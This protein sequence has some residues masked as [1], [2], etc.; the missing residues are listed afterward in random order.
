MM[1]PITVAIITLFLLSQQT[2]P[3]NRPGGGLQATITQEAL[4][5]GII[6]YFD[7]RT[8][9]VLSAPSAVRVGADFQMAI[10]TF[11]GGCERGGD[12]SVI[13]T[14]T[15]ATVIVYDFTTATRPGVVCTTILKRMPHVVTFRFTKPGDALIRVW[16]RRIGSETA[17]MG[18]P[19]VLE[20]RVMV[21]TSDLGQAPDQPAPGVGWVVSETGIG[22][23]RIGMTVAEAGQALQDVL[24]GVNQA[25]GCYFVRPSRGLSGISFMV[26]DGRIVRVDVENPS[27]ATVTGARVGDSEERIK[28][29]YPQVEIAPHKYTN[30]H[31]LTVLPG[32]NYRIIFETDGLKVTRYRAGRLPEVGW[33]EGCS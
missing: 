33:V 15:G 3:S 5:P 21:G 26:A 10:T 28:R 25:S 13:V 20:H 24:V 27:I 8:K 6:D 17:S 4:V 16:G 2:C 12:T 19:V 30:G 18:V 11:G 14:E 32:G 7:E 29:L 31:Y 1:K 23:V 9:D 22:P